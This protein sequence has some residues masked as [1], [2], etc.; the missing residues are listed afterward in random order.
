MVPY[1]IVRYIDPLWLLICICFRKH[2]TCFSVFRSLQLSTI[3]IAFFFD[4]FPS[5][6]LS[7]EFTIVWLEQ[8]SYWPTCA[9]HI[10]LKAIFIGLVTNLVRTYVG[11]GIRDYVSPISLQRAALLKSVTCLLIFELVSGASLFAF[12]ARQQLL[13]TCVGAKV[14][15][16]VEVSF[17]FYVLYFRKLLY[18]YRHLSTKMLILCCLFSSAYLWFAEISAQE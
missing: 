12:A 10:M 5:L 9:K 18:S 8:L 17:H 14:T 2:F 13:C 4:L 6:L 11:A 15:D 3:T 7:I 1:V 16:C